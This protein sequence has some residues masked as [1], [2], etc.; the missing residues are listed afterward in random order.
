[1]CRNALSRERDDSARA[2]AYLGSHP[3]LGRVCE[4]GLFPSIRDWERVEQDNIPD[5]K[6]CF[7]QFPHPS[8]AFDA[9]QG[10]LRVFQSPTNSVRH[11]YGILILSPPTFKAKEHLAIGEMFAFGLY[12]KFCRQNCSPTTIFN[13]ELDGLAVYQYS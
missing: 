2:L 9:F 11:I 4:S 5:F 13:L 3:I 8:N 1:M 7:Q 6:V 12:W 10:V